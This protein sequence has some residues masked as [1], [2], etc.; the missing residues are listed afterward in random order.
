LTEEFVDK[1]RARY[2]Y[3]HEM[4]VQNSDAN[5]CRYANHVSS[6]GEFHL[7]SFDADYC[8]FYIGI[9][10]ARFNTETS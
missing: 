10:L 3:E 5:F 7:P 4:R 6:V 2:E 1:G 8:T 9:L